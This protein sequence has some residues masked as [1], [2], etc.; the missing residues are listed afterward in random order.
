MF[1]CRCCYIKCQVV[2]EI[3]LSG[4]GTDSLA[5]DHLDTGDITVGYWTVPVF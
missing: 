2:P 3:T 5:T 1:P 4:T